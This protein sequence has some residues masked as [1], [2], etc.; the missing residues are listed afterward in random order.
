M[1][2]KV[3]NRMASQAL[4]SVVVSSNPP[5]E[6]TSSSPHLEPLSFIKAT[7]NNKKH[8]SRYGVGA[9]WMKQVEFADPQ[10]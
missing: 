3:K 6:A 2:E 9:F 1:V 4:P 8:H 5:M 10:G 7:K